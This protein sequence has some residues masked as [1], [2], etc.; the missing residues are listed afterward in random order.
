M[1]ESTAVRRLQKLAEDWPETLWLFAANGTLNVMRYDE[2]GEQVMTGE[3]CVDSEH[4]VEAI[5]IPCD[6]G[7]W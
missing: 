4:I 2:S 7:G 6:G 1:R 5:D 3:G